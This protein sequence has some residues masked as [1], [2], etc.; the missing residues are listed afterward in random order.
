MK[1]I[2]RHEKKE[3]QRRLEE[4]ERIRKALEEEERKRLEEEERQ[5]REK[6]EA[7]RKRLEEKE[8]LRREQLEEQR[9]RELLQRLSPCEQGFAWIKKGNRYNCAG[10]GHWVTEDELKRAYTHYYSK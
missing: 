1:E 10:G 4:E 7:E 8:R 9:K 2:K 5:R 6:A 3:R